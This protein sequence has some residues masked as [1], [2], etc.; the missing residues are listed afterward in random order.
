MNRVIE[1][2]VHHGVAANLLMAVMVVG[3]LVAI[4]F[5]PLKLFPDLD[6]GIVTI[7]VLYPGASPVEVEQGVCIPIEEA[8]QSVVGIENIRGVAGEGACRM[9]VELYPGTDGNLVV[10]NV[11]NRV[12]AIQNFPDEAET[13]IVAKLDYRTPVIDLAVSGDLSEAERKRI[14]TRIRDDLTNID[15]ITQ[16]DLEYTRNYEIS[17]EV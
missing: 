8:I 2:F 7:D 10:T 5:I 3:G 14:G 11:R 17:I 9:W 15:G 4:P 1:W 16:V 13:P 12:D 6:F